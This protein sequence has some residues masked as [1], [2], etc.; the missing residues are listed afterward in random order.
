M[1]K[2]VGDQLTLSL[3]E[4]FEEKEREWII[5]DMG[6]DKADPTSA[7]KYFNII[8]TKVGILEKKN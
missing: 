5:S 4:A 2:K 8:L 7:E 1:G 3:K 6:L